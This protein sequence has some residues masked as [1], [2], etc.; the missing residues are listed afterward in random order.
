M[1]GKSVDLA[2]AKIDNIN[3]IKKTK[4]EKIKNSYHFL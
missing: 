2:N 4:R 1:F 3:A